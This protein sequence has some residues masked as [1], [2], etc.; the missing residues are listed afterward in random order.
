MHKYL[1]KPDIGVVV[2]VVGK[3]CCCFFCCLLT[4][5]SHVVFHLVVTNVTL[6]LLLGELSLFESTTVGDSSL[7]PTPK[8]S[9]VSFSN[10]HHLDYDLQMRLNCTNKLELELNQQTR[11]N[12][13][14]LN[15]LSSSVLLT[16]KVKGNQLSSLVLY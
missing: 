12:R 15:K 9:F 8:S 6:V 2:I 3:C 4:R 1:E 7:S 13:D 14:K 5:H 10:M 11:L 16:S